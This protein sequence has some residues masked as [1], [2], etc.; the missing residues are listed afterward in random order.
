MMRKMHK[1]SVSIQVEPSTLN[2]YTV[3]VNENRAFARN[4]F[5]VL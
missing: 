1:Y 5:T 3:K 2:T 4:F